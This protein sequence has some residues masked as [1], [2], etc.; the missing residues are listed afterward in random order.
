MVLPEDFF[1]LTTCE[2]RALFADLPRVWEAL[3]RLEDYLR[4]RLTPGLR[5]LV[6][7]GAWVQGEVCLGEGSVVQPGALIIGPV[8]IGR[9]CEIRHGALVRGPA[10]IAD[11][12]VVG[13]GSEVKQAILLEGARASHLNYVGDSILGAEANLGAGTVCA[14]LKLTH[15]PIV[16]RTPHG[17]HPT[18]LEKLGAI[19]GDRVQIGANSTLAPGTLVGPRSLTYQAASL[20][21]WY[22]PDSIIKARSTIEVVARRDER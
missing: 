2:H 11:R 16:I 13:H 22:P 18:R 15:D 4:D 8:L 1:D 10:L 21:G 17:D 9:R 19:L 14:N 5:G 6:M 12:A 7:P 3:A 20:R